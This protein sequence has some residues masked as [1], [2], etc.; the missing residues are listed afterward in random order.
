ML[1]S[2]ESK[3]RAHLARLH[4]ACMAVR[5]FTRWSGRKWRSA[6]NRRVVACTARVA[7]W[8]LL[9]WTGLHDVW[10]PAPAPWGGESWSVSEKTQPAT[11][12]GASG[13]SRL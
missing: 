7:G 10:D 13:E 6:C 4:A 1:G 11:V 5:P 2:L 9:P 12:E 3:G 8:L